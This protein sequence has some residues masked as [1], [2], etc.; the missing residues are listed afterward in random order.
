MHQLGEGQGRIQL[1]MGSQLW[2]K[3][4]VCGALVAWSLQLM[5]PRHPADI[6]QTTTSDVPRLSRNS[7]PAKLRNVNPDCL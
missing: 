2:L 3:V 4:A 5:R 6:E 1:G 7:T